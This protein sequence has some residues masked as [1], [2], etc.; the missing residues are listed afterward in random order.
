MAI[1]FTAQSSALLLG[2]LVFSAQAQQVTPEVPSLEALLQQETNT[3][4]AQVEVST[5]ARYVQNAGQSSQITYIVTDEEISRF[6]LRNMGEILSFFPGIYVSTDSTYGY[7]TARGIGRPGDYNSRLLFLVDG[8]RVND[9]IYDAGLIGSNFYIDPQLIDRVEYSPGS[10]SAL[11]GNNAFLGVVNI[12]TKRSNKMQGAQLG[13]TLDDQHQ[14]ELSVAYGL[15]DLDGQE[16][17][18]SFNHSQ[19][20]EIGFSELNSPPLLREQ[21][22]FN[23]DLNQKLAASYRYRRWQLQFAGVSRVRQEPVVVAAD[24]AISD[25]FRTENQNYFLS[26]QHGLSL[27]EQVEMYTHLSTNSFKLKTYTPFI[28]PNGR[29]SDYLFDVLGQWTNLDLRFSYSAAADHH[30]LFGIDG[31]RDH[32]QSYELSVASLAPF[33]A[34]SSD[35]T[36]SGVYLQHDWQILPDHTFISGF[37]YDYSDQDVR[38]FSPKLGWIWHGVKQHLFRLSYGT[39]FRAP[40][41][42]EQKSNLYLAVPA[43]ESEFIETLEASWQAQLE[44]GWTLGASVYRS[45]IRNLIATQS[46]QSNQVWFGNDPKVKAHGIEATLLK[47]WPHGSQFQVSATAQRAHY[48]NHQG[49]TNSP[50]RLLKADYSQPLWRD[51]LHLNWRLFASSNRP[52]PIQQLPGFARHDLLV[53]WQGNAQLSLVFGVKNILDRR[54]LDAPLP[55]AEGLIQPGRSAELSL[56]WTFL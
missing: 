9:N 55:T 46:P 19:R 20:D 29:Q 32:H 30:L 27:S 47:K 33:L 34:V 23:E 2:Y 53:S 3:D 5:S 16:G 39:A 11:Y 38:E 12:I 17:W 14:R 54:Y 51:N 35:N 44:D 48:E 22:Q 24:P 36:R 25:I 15:R 50:E 43:P 42:Y 18:L 40:N 26:M 52:H 10:G 37:R 8:T 13:V 45:S 31:Q 4:P 21:R 1:R 49:L 56:R 28:L 7:L 41:E 6:S